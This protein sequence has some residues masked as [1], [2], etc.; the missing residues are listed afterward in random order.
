MIPLSKES[1]VRFM[2][3]KDVTPYHYGQNVPCQRKDGHKNE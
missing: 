3:R 2:Q 1:F